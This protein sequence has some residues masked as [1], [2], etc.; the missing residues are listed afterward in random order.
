MPLKKGMILSKEQSHH[1]FVKL[2]CFTGSSKS[3][4]F[5]LFAFGNII[6]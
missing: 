3:Y 1:L 4:R 5:Y 2:I 6:I